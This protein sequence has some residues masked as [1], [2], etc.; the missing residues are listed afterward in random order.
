MTRANAT[1]PRGGL[2]L[3]LLVTLLSAT[4]AAA[5]GVGPLQS[6]PLPPPDEERLERLDAFLQRRLTERPSAGLSVGFSLGDFEWMRGYGYRDVE[7]EL[8]ATPDTSY[9][10]ASVTKVMTAV[11]VLQLVERGKV[12]LDADVRRYVPS[13]PKKRWPTTVRQLLGHLGGISH[14]RDCRLE[15]HLKTRHSTAQALSI[16]QGWPLVA[17]PGDEYVYTSY[18]YNLL[19]AV[20]ERRSGLPYGKYLERRIFAPAGMTASGMDGAG[21]KVH[22]RAQ[23]Y[24]VEGGA[25]VPSEHVDI[26][27]RFAGGGAR[28]TVRDMLRFGRAL[29]GDALLR[30]DTRERM[31]M[32]MT[33]SDGVLTD[34]GMGVAV[35]P[36]SGRYVVAHAGAQPETSTYL[37]MFPAEDLVIF[38]ATNVEDQWPL[39][40]EVVEKIASVVLGDGS[41]RR[42]PIG[43]DNVSAVQVDA[44]FGTMGHGLAW[45]TRFGRPLA[46]SPGELLAA[47]ERLAELTDPAQI[48]ED[49]AAARA[50]ENLGD[51]PAGGQVYPKV[52]S[53]M[54]AVLARAYGPGHL[55]RYAVDGPLPFVLDYEQACAQL[56]CPEGLRLPAH[57]TKAARRWLP[58]WERANHER[59]R[60]LEVRPA[61]DPSAL[62]VLLD[63][64]F[65]GADVHPDLSRELAAAGSVHVAAGDRERALAFLE[66]ALRLHPTSPV[67]L[68]ALAEAKLSF[69]EL[70]DVSALLERWHALERKPDEDKAKSLRL[71]ARSLLRDGRTEPARALLE[72]A[73][74]LFPDDAG[75]KAALDKLPPRNRTSRAA[76][77][78]R[79]L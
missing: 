56:D 28:S 53:H 70:D 14:Y 62:A 9:R 20:V 32:S 34:Y 21:R 64:A 12:D 44:L 33:T 35:Y 68:R 45:Y 41:A 19:G 76:D 24:R 72:I 51:D 36:Q 40:R 46:T 43:V 25:L 10:L 57:I 75:L 18:G 49:L 59:V 30:E 48:G 66:L 17:R 2:V 31:Q 22:E 11:A 4:S 39:L 47:F 6:A 52:G 13:F 37:V 61:D 15:C 71:K 3:A 16:F 55:R 26:S 67:A 63:E 65:Q 27:S 23:G 73:Q 42:F 7:N 1:P 38:V 8:P 5:H 60:F 50:A 54:A 29:L 78:G 69:G 74:R 58:A 79:S 77:E